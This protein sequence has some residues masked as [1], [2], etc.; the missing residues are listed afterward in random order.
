MSVVVAKPILFRNGKTVPVT[1]MINDR[2]IQ[3]IRDL[4]WRKIKAT[5]PNIPSGK[6]ILVVDRELAFQNLVAE[7]LPNINLC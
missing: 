3:C 6:H 7:L 1:F 2:K 4:F 5:I